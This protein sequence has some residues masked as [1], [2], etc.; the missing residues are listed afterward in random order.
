M[1]TRRAGW[2]LLGAFVATLAGAAYVGFNPPGGEPIGVID[3]LWAASF[4]GFPTA[5]AL[6]INRH[7][8][9][10]LG[11]ILSLAPLLLMFGVLCSE[12]ARYGLRDPSFPGA[13]IYWVGTITFN[14]GMGLLLLTPL[15]LPNGLLLS[16]RWRVAVWPLVIYTMLAVVA[17]ALGP[18]EGEEGVSNP[19]GI[20]ALG[21]FFDL[22]EAMLGA[23]AI[24]ALGFGTLSLILRFRRSTGAER[25]QMKMLA[26]GALGVAASLGALA[27]TEAIL[28]DQSDFVATIFI[29]FAILSLPASIALAVMRYRLYDVDLVINRTLVYGSLT[30]I[31][32]ASYFGIVVVLQRVLGPLTQDSDLAVAGSTLAVAALF[33]PLRARVQSFIDRRFYRR[34][35]DATETLDRFSSRLRDEVDL[36]ALRSDIVGVV[37]ETMQPT[38]ASLWLRPSG[39]E[40]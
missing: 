20:A 25:Q 10:A 1:K 26:L 17:G 18:W 30:A 14:V 39:A 24:W 37:Q 7:P 13:W 28:G 34:K 6:V 11:W 2:L 40:Q 3:A 35:Y 5:G 9:R 29:I 32:F 16:R 23:A 19:I 8:R 27:T 21:G 31:L 15:F 36:D 22:V 4:V 33:R 38:H 12:V